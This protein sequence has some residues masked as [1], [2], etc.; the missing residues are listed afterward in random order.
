MLSLHAQTKFELPDTTLDLSRYKDAEVCLAA[1]SRLKRQFNKFNRL[2]DDTLVVSSN[3]ISAHLSP[4]IHEI[5]ERCSSQFDAES[6]SLDQFGHWINLFLEADRDLDAKRVLER[7]T[8]LIPSDSV[9]TLRAILMEAL[10]E[11]MR[12]RPLRVSAA[13]AVLEQ[14][15][16]VLDPND[17]GGF[18]SL[19]RDRFI[20]YKDLLMDTAQ[21]TRIA[22]AI[23]V[24]TS[25]LS[26]QQRKSES[27]LPLGADLSYKAQSFLKREELIDSLQRSTAAFIALERAIWNETAKGLFSHLKMTGEPAKK[28]DWSFQ[29]GRKSS[30]NISI[31]GNSEADEEGLNREFPQTGRIGLVVFLRSHC[32]DETSAPSRYDRRDRLLFS[33]CMDTYAILRRL[34]VRFPEL[35]VI[36]VSQ[37]TGHVGFSKALSPAEEASLLGQWWLDYHRLPGTLLVTETRFFHLPQPDGRRV[38]EDVTNNR[39]YGLL[40]GMRDF[41]YGF[42]IDPD[43]AIIHS[44]LLVRS[45]ESDFVHMIDA[46]VKRERNAASTL[47]AK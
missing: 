30:D 1:T 43:G 31:V 40:D 45:S 25:T 34:S 7:R 42:L 12:I 10:N 4:D 38:D 20:L 13:E 41:R 27:Y 18:Y 9:D 37:T 32:R 2:W 44:G 35:D 23:L 17:V 14:I 3:E 6:V 16:A 21:A 36:L 5:A 39:H 47:G 11:Y 29:L 19:Y 46:L 15:E 33:D 24:K 26:D 22:S 8:A 28:L